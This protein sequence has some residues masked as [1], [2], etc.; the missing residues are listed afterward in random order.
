V[1]PAAQSFRRPRVRLRRQVEVNRQLQQAE[2]R[3]CPDHRYLRTRRR[4]HLRMQ[5]NQMGP[6]F[7][8][9]APADMARLP[10]SIITKYI[11]LVVNN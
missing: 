5:D 8:R 3:Q 4:M 9:L 1:F 6:K 7:V 11:F 10:P 2:R